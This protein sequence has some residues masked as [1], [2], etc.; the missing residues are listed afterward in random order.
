LEKEILQQHGGSTS[1]L[2]V[3]TPV[4]PTRLVPGLDRVSSSGN[5]K[6]KHISFLRYI[7]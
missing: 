4:R 5:V 3:H 6:D 7:L 1:C 2:I